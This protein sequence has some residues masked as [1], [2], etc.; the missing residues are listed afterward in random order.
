M[1]ACIETSPREP[2]A[3]TTM[4]SVTLH[5][6]EQVASLALEDIPSQVL[7][8]ARLCI[9]D[10]LGAALQGSR[11]PSSKLVQALAAAEGGTPLASIWGRSLRASAL[12]AALLNGVSAHALDYD[13]THQ[14]VP[15]HV[16]ATVLPAVFAAAEL[17]GKTM[18]ELLTGY[19]AGAEI[20]IHAG[21]ALGRSHVQ[22]GWHPTGTV[23]T[24]G[25][26][27][28]AAHVLGLQPTQI[29]Q[30]LGLAVTQAAGFMKAVTGNMAK[31]LNAGKAS[32]NGLLS[33]LLIRE[34]FSGPDDVFAS[35]SDFATAF[36][37]NFDPASLAFGGNAGW[38]ISNIAIK[39]SACC[40]LAQAALEGGR[41][42]WRTHH[43][44][45]HSI[46]EVE[47]EANPRQVQI[48]G[49]PRPRTGLEAKFSLAYCT[50]LGLCNAT[51]DSSDFEDGRLQSPGL[52]A[53]MEK[54]SIRVNPALSEVSARV[55]VKTIGGQILEQFVA[56]AR[57][58]PG[59]PATT[60][61]VKA[62]FHSLAGP[63]LGER[64]DKLIALMLEGASMQMPVKELADILTGLAG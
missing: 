44:Q 6:A 15:L 59:N 4:T 17:T 16:T 30:V 3:D 46:A 63:A 57:G 50:A 61:E 20:A 25:A 64:R 1:D 49:I 11:E 47:L 60:D 23:G 29:A 27:A 38:E 51:G 56:I 36:S 13:D 12:Q 28:G 8:H 19:V 21:L 37:E 14:G 9:L 41:A 58:N 18:R 22:R 32:M 42:I 39:L 53:L 48:A 31:P 24:L 7:G 40:S 5:L 26:A 2:D 54:V 35:G 52:A 10:T 43:I 62:K 45:D 55:R 34:G 33:S